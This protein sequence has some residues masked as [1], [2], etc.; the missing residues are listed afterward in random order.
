[1][2]L[3]SEKLVFIIKG[4]WIF[5]EASKSN[6]GNILIALYKE[7]YIIDF[8]IGKIAFI[9]KGLILLIGFPNNS[10]LILKTTWGVYYLGVAFSIRG[11]GVLP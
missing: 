11:N 3:R 7:H 6:F 9:I 10:H 1:M 4:N 2:I 5:G 8:E